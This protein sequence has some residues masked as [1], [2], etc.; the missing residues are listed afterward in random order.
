MWEKVVYVAN[1]GT[2]FKSE[3]E[4]FEYEMKD[5]GAI[6]RNTD[7]FIAYDS[8][9][10]PMSTETPELENTLENAYFMSV[11]TEEA[12]EALE[13]AQRAYNLGLPVP[14]EIGL[15]RWDD[16]NSE[17]REL[18]DD[19]HELNDIWAALGKKFTIV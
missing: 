14:E 5:A 3:E 2:E 6:L 17:W 1:D 13:T 9:V 11:K 16:R 7:H 18:L 19:L 8:N 12:V 4:A 15:F 10:R